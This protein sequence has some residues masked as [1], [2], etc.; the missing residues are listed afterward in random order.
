MLDPK[1]DYF[2]FQ[3]E[4]FGEQGDIYQGCSRKH[5]LS[6]KGAMLKSQT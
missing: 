2:D 3:G 4:V 1:K 6:A 5:R